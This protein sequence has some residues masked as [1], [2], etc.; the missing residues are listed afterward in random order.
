MPPGTMGSMTSERVG[1]VR[2]RVA[3]IGPILPVLASETVLWLGFGA[4]LPILP[5]YITERGMDAA[6]LGLIVAAWPATRLIAEPVFG[7]LAD[8]HDRRLLMIAGLVGTGIVVPLPLF[9]G[10]ALAF[11]VLRGLAGLF[12]A[13]YDP[14]ARGYILEAVPADERGWA[15]G[16]YSAAQMGGFLLGPA[17]GGVGAALFGGYAFPF[18]FCGVA[19]FV[20]AAVL[21]V[22]TRSHSPTVAIRDAEAAGVSRDHAG[23]PHRLFNRVLVAAMV[24]NLGAY[25][26]SGTYEVIWSLWMKGI[27][28]DLG[29]IGLSFAAF[30]VGVLILSPVAGRLID[31]TGPVRFVIVGSILP[32]CAG[33][34][35]PSIHDPRLAIPLVVVEGIGFALSGP[36]LFTIAG[37]GTPPG[38]SSTAQGLL[39]GAGTLGF[40]AASLSAGILF[41]AHPGLPFY[42]FA[43]GVAA[44]LS[45]GIAIGGRALVDGPRPGEAT[46]G[47]APSTSPAVAS[48]NDPA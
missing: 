41:E 14:A 37:R 48:T 9:V 7:W 36:A 13:A 24:V 29:L 35:Y 11:V 8:R 16:L 17:I 10:G 27:G 25:F 33:V 28:A 20:G 4:L 15:F 34:L 12:T 21:A 44:T 23:G 39:G 42:V 26:A 3:R 47:L 40:I 22:T 30:S 32:A 18:V 31:R 45:I 2:G 6:T 19:M 1:Q 43:V 38:R 46:A 5:L